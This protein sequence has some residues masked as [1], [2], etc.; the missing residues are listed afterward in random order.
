MNIIDTEHL[1]LRSWKEEDI[2]PMGW[3]LA[4]TGVTQ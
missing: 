1:I 4:E 3:N 2:E